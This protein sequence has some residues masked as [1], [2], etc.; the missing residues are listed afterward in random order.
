[1]P[2]ADPL[3]LVVLARDGSDR[4]RSAW[5]EVRDFLESREDVELLAA[6]LDEDLDEA[7]P[8]T[9]M[10]VVLGGD[11]AMLRAS[12][13]FGTRQ[14]PLLGVN[15]GRLGFLADLSPQ[16]FFDRF[17]DLSHRAYE[18]RE[19][20][21]FR[22]RLRRNGEYVHDETGAGGEEGFLGLNELAVSSRTLHMIEVRLEI[23]GVP[24]TTY[25][26][27]GLI[28]STPVGSTAHNLSAGGPILRQDLRAF[29]VTPICPHTLTVRPLVDVADAVYTLALQNDCDGATATVDGRTR[30]PMSCGDVLELS[31]AEVAC[32]LVKLP[33]A[34][35]YAAL[36]NKLGWGGQ[37]RYRR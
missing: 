32:P 10:A 5:R 25:N 1:M 17:E 16:E 14:V 22:V 8:G 26:G 21:M 15:L 36:H 33:G 18:I 12:H 7:P 24:V 37:P 30:L 11:G 3:R 6:A 9:E 19:H 29:V 20:L 31:A 34:N 27:D 28:V 4:V 23:G 2:H 13:M 35:F